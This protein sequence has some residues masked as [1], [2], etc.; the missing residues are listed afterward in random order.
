MANAQDKGSIKAVFVKSMDVILIILATA[1]F[2]ALFIYDYK[3]GEMPLWLLVLA[4]IS[5]FLYSLKNNLS[6]GGAG[7]LF[8]FLFFGFFYLVSKGKLIGTGDLLLGASLAFIV[9]WPNSLYLIVSAA[10]LGLIFALWQRQSKISFA[11]FLI[12]AGLFVLAFSNLSN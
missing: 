1:I 10:F 11:P 12:F 6:S 8:V 9:G 3:T 4:L 2:S 7:A 5:G